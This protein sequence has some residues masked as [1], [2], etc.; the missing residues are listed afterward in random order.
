MI[1]RKENNDNFIE[2]IHEKLLD[3]FLFHVISDWKNIPTAINVTCVYFHMNKW[4]PMWS[5]TSYKKSQ[6]EKDPIVYSVIG[7]AKG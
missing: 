7:T 3:T 6:P 5:H 2:L 1:R 4:L